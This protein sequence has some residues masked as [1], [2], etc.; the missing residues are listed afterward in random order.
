[1][2][3]LFLTNYYPPYHIGGFEELCAE[4]VEGLSQRGHQ[5]GVLT[6]HGGLDHPQITDDG[7]HRLLYPV[8]DLR[9]LR[10]PLG[11]FIG[12]QK[13]VEKDL[14]ILNDVVTRFRPDVLMICGMWNL[15][16]QLL[17]LAESWDNPKVIYYFAD[18]W[19]LL[20][21][22]YTLYWKEPPNLKFSYYPK[23]LL[24][25]L[26]NNF[27]QKG[28]IPQ[29]KYL[30]FN[31]TI[32]VSEYLC[33]H[34]K[35]EGINIKNSKVIYN[36]INI[37]SFFHVKAEK[38]S[39]INNG[40]LKLLYAGRIMH[41]K[42]VHTAIEA[43]GI[44]KKRNLE[45]TLT[46]LGKGTINYIDKLV[47]LSGNL[48][49]SQQIKFSDYVPRQNLPDVISNYD[50]L[51]FPSMLDEALPRIILEAM[52]AGLVVVGTN[53]GGVPEIL[54]DK[55]NGLCFSPGSATELA[56]CLEHLIKNQDQMSQYLSEAY[57]MIAQK[58][59]IKNTIEDI[60]KYILE[61]LT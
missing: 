48:G 31:N 6:T 17:N 5:I 39:S 44:L 55:R 24:A 22:A 2:R 9:P 42:G 53:V 34:L 27:D 32:C 28:K 57:S 51:V 29:S 58:F 23:R 12:R 56:D 16:V 45:V 3:V 26:V 61:V 33:R 36:G 35:S 18:I 20:P 38:R 54:K 11:F 52:A 46:I 49:I 8:V 43:L 14:A 30:L 37:N 10:G 21:D 1:M 47:T 4:V 19:P 7:V 40:Q 60:E 13:R 25:W 41:E 15:P 50:V 59:D